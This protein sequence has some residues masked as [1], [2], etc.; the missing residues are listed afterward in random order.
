ML[1]EIELRKM[2][3]KKLRRYLHP[4]LPLAPHR[5]LSRGRG[6]VLFCS[7]NYLGLTHHPRVIAAVQKAVARFGTGSGA[8]PLIS[9]YTELHQ[10]LADRLARFKGTAR[11]LLFP[12]GYSANVGLMSSITGPK[13]VVFVDRFAHASL[14][15]GIKLGGAK[16]VRF[17]H[18][19]IDHL[20]LL[21]SRH[22]GRRRFLVTEGV[23]SMDGDTAPLA[24]LATLARREE[25]IFIVDDAH[26][27]GVLGPQG[28]GTLAAQGVDPE[29][30]IIVGTLSKALAAA[31]GFV[32][33]DE[34]L[35][36]FLLNRARSFIFST[37]LPPPVVAAAIS[38]LRVLE[39]DPEPQA[40]L[41]ANISRLAEG[42][43]ALGLPASGETPIFPV[44]LGSEGRA[45]K[46]ASLLFAKGFYVPAIRPPTVP[47][48]TARLR[49]SVNALHTPYEV[50]S[51]LKALA[52]TLKEV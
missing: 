15:D 12:S 34:N 47:P 43:K 41:R 25:L 38:A 29:G 44:V 51:F 33:G 5:A 4:L 24:E 50:N 42:L 23:F 20:E 18:N 22:R 26:G 39:E 10:E 35:I 14:L 31:G 16:L 2:E 37:S 9:G 52:E 46:V 13:D 28:R 36:D 27:T 21:L 30:I 6:M 8:S 40:R 3:E 7:N 1:W 48:G 17:R 45:L 49:V 19:D 11:A 32:A